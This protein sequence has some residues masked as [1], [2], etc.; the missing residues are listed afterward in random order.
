MRP[1][2][3]GGAE[4]QP[5]AGGGGDTRGGAELTKTG[6]RVLALYQQMEAKVAKATQ[7]PLGQILS[8]LKN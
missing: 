1:L 8:C 2:S 5:L 4:N 6:K 3:N 7:G